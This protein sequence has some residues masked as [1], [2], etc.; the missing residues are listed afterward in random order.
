MIHINHQ[1][2]WALSRRTIGLGQHVHGLLVVLLPQGVAGL[3]VARLICVLRNARVSLG[4][5]GSKVNVHGS[6]VKESKFSESKVNDKSS[7]VDRPFF[8]TLK[9]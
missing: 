7:T 8:N 1:P 6:M 9:P 3:V 5:Q 2:M 4:G